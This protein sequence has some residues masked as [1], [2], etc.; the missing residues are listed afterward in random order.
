MDREPNDPADW[1]RC[2]DCGYDLRGLADTTCPEC[3]TPFTE[4]ELKAK[5]ESHAVMGRATRYS[6]LAFPV[7]FLFLILSFGIR[8]GYEWIIAPHQDPPLCINDYTDGGD[9]TYYFL[10][11]ELPVLMAALSSIAI[12]LALRQRIHGQSGSHSV[13]IA[14]ASLFILA[15]GFLL[16]CTSCIAGFD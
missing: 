9:A 2:W 6:T 16:G 11:A 4:A 13:V 15:L 8:L 7:F 5:H 12:V 1:L 3:G 14:V 10:V